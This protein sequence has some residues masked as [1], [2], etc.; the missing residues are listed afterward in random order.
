[1]TE[2]LE[3][4]QAVDE[5]E[6]GGCIGRFAAVAAGFQLG[7][8]VVD[9]GRD[10]L[11][12]RDNHIVRHGFE[13]AFKEIRIPRSGAPRRGEGRIGR[14]RQDTERQAP[15]ARVRPW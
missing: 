15:G 12:A 11:I 10:L 13:D 14:P 8:N 9:D 2:F 6:N 5:E 7:G 1:M 4:V 3:F